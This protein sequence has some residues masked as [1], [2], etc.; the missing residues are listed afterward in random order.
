MKTD[1]KIKTRKIEVRGFSVDVVI[2]GYGTYY[3]PSFNGNAEFRAN[4]SGFRS[5]CHYL[6]LIKWMNQIK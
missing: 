6:G 4:G 3:Y 5:L 2:Y 1:T